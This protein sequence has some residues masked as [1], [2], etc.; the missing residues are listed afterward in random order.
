MTRWI[1]LAALTLGLSL[2]QPV[3]VSAD[4]YA[5]EGEVGFVEPEQVG[6]G[7]QMTESAGEL[8]ADK[9]PPAPPKAAAR[10][11][12]M[13]QLGDTQ[14]VLCTLIGLLLATTTFLLLMIKRH[15]KDKEEG[16]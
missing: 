4:T 5:T 12:L 2:Q 7:I 6:G 10:S 9:P 1:L 16:N 14:T 15:E 8:P 13:P 11:G 3:T